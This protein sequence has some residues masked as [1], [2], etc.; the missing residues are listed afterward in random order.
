[1]TLSTLMM[2]PLLL[3][4]CFKFTMDL[5]VSDQ[6]MVSGTAV[7]AVSKQLEAFAE[8]GVDTEATD[9]FGGIDGVTT[10]AFDDGAFVGQSYSFS[11][12]PLENF[13]P[14]DDGSGLAIIRIGDNLVVSGDL[15][16][17]DDSADLEAGADLGFGQAIFDSADIRISI[18]FPGTILETN[19]VINED[20]NT[21]TWSPQYGQENEISAVV[22]APQGWP[23][24]VWWALG[25]VVAVAIGV[26]VVLY[27]R[28]T[29]RKGYYDYVENME[30]FS[31]DD[32]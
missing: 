24:W 4:G 13:T 32:P 25:G 26:G 22:S 1:M 16:F 7:V 21:I 20:T 8:P 12:V 3:T 2:L 18:T 10:E 31:T 6:D 27:V 29:R 15:S 9:A 17:V 23:Y 28:H 11:S 14:L 30:P 19:G 5:E